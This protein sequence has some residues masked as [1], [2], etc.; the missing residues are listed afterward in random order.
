LFAKKIEYL[1]RLLLDEDFSSL[2]VE[3][4]DFYNRLESQINHIRRSKSETGFRLARI[5]ATFLGVNIQSPPYVSD[6]EYAQIE[7]AAYDLK[8]E[9]DLLKEEALNCTK[10]L[11]LSQKEVVDLQ[12][13][14]SLFA[15]KIQAI[16]K[17]LLGEEISLASVKTDEFYDRIDMESRVLRAD[18]QRYY[19][20]LHKIG[21]IALQDNDFESSLGSVS[22]DGIDRIVEAISNLRECEANYVESLR[23]SQEEVAELREENRSLRSRYTER[24][25]QMTEIIIDV[26]Q[27]LDELITLNKV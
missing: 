7:K 22:K 27:K 16:G 10:S 26:K 13:E 3:T 5:G 2:D 14:I 6:S 4:D 24:Q 15:G 1:G 25:A 12:Q 21:A 20:H 23:L 18:N 19:L 17:F 11:Q 8:V 9:R